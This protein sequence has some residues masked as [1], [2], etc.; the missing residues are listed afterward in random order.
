MAFSVHVMSLSF[1]DLEVSSTEF[2][3]TA[4]IRGKPK[5]SDLT[6]L[7]VDIQKFDKA[8]NIIVASYISGNRFEFNKV[9]KELKEFHLSS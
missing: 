1:S 5:D 2:A 6:I 9:F 7:R 3:V 4:Q 8:K